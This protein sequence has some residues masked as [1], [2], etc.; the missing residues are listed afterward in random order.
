MGKEAA[1]LLSFSQGWGPRGLSSTSRTARGQ[2][3]RPWPWPRSLV[4]DDLAPVAFNQRAQVKVGLT[5][6]YNVILISTML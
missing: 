5:L 2:K 1:R 4:F 6:Y 3:S